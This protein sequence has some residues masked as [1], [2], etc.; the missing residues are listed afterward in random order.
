MRIQLLQTSPDAQTP[1]RICNR[2]ML[3]IISQ[4][5]QE[6]MAPCKVVVSTHMLL[7]VSVHAFRAP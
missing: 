1:L 5:A 2:P 7:K 4:Y 3:S 6:L